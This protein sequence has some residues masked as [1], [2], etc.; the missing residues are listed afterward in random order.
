MP[1][2]HRIHIEIFVNMEELVFETPHEIDTKV[3]IFAMAHDGPVAWPATHAGL[4][5]IDI[6][7]GIV[8]KGA[9]IGL[10]GRIVVWVL[11][12]IDIAL[13]ANTLIA[14]LVVDGVGAAG[15]AEEHRAN[16]N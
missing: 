9:A 13:Q 2:V 5:E 14:P 16:K 11:R 12:D 8:G 1:V 6:E 10:E 4:Y 7:V 3:G 15:T